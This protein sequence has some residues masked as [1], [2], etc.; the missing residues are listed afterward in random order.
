[1]A[2]T[3]TTVKTEDA[4]KAFSTER[5]PYQC[6]YCGKVG[7]TME[8]CWKKQKDECRGADAAAMPVDAG[9]IIVSMEKDVSRLWAV[10]SGATHH[11]CHDKAKFASLIEREDGEISVADGNKAAIKGVG[12]IIF[13]KVVLLNGNERESRSRTRSTYQAWQ[14]PSDV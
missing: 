5:V 14:V 12:T 1:M 8:R 9:L 4:T 11:I 3:T 2:T 10:D 7:Y 13:D 6:T